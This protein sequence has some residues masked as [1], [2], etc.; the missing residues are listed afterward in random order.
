MYYYHIFLSSGA[1]SEMDSAL[2]LEL[3]FA[4]SVRQ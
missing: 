3:E 1:T 2:L 4:V